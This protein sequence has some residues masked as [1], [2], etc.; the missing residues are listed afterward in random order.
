MSENNL[1]TTLSLNGRWVIEIGEQHGTVQVP[2]VWEAQGYPSDINQA[3]YTRQV[4]IPQ[5]WEGKRVTIRFGAVSYRVEVFVNEQTVGSHD[6]L[7]TAFAYDIQDALDFG[8]ENTIRLNIE[9]PSNVKDDPL[10]YRNVL[11]GFI[12]YISSTFGGVWKDIDLIVHDTPTWDNIRVFPDWQTK[13]LRVT[14]QAQQ[15]QDDL[16]THLT[17]NNPTG[18]VV[19][20][21]SFTLDATGKVDLTVEL[22]DVE[23]WSPEKANVYQL[24]LGLEQAGQVISEATRTFGFRSLLADGDQLRFN[25]QPIHLRGTLHWGWQPHV[26]API[27]TDAEIREEFQ[28]IRAMGFNL[29]KLCLFVPTENF[30]RIADEE[31]MLLWLEFPMWWQLMN[32]HLREQLPIEYQAILDEVHHHPSIVLYSL[33]CELEAHM[34][35]ADLLS[36]LSDLVRDGIRDCLICDNSGSSEAYSGAIADLSDFYDY[37]FYS[38]LHQFS[39]LIDHFH[40]DWRPAR[41]WIF[42]EFCAYDDVR[43]PAL[44]V[45]DTGER[46]AWRDLLGTDGGIHRWAYSEQEN[47]V[48]Q[49]DLPF[50]ADELVEKARQQSWTIRKTILEKTRARRQMGGYVVCGF[51]DTPITTAGVWDDF[52]QPKYPPEKFKQINHDTVLTMHQGRRRVWQ[53]GDQPAPLDDYNFHSEQAV[54]VYLVV[55]HVGDAIEDGVLRWELHDDAGNVFISGKLSEIALSGDGI[56]ITVANLHWTFPTIE[57]AQ[58]WELRATLD[59]Y[60]HNSWQLHLYPETANLDD[61]KPIRVFTRWTDEIEQFIHDGGKGIHIQSESDGLPTQTV[62]FWQ[63]S[64]PLLYE[65]PIWENFP[66][67]GYV[68]AN[69]YHL[70]TEIAFD[71]DALAEM[72]PDATIQSVMRRLHTRLFTATDYVVE[73]QL[74]KGRLLASTLRFQGGLGDQVRGLDSNIAGQHLLNSMID[75]LRTS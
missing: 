10:G 57:Q 3:T 70:A 25:D 4:T 39:P 36:H 7:W 62:G 29:V 9:K 26:R 47:R 1:A 32:P 6:G 15:I 55:S 13:T 69:F 35:D 73:I 71:S 46:L 38:D 37:H 11:V 63:E 5:E 43:N 54:M 74:G 18:Q 64:L 20:H 17:I 67:K 40:R 22:A 68:G 41:P 34:A 56:P 33:G 72:F 45:D 50:S 23:A 66:H 16:Q 58:I 60:N 2:A 65:H 48:A 42:G 75:Y 30:F 59:G 28:W 61:S 52:D 27:F 31:G 19:H 53:N 49:L 24:T 51:R 21:S 12:P 44:L 14:A 8:D